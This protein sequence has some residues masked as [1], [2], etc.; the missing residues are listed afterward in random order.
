MP[1]CAVFYIPD[2]RSWTSCDF[3]EAWNIQAYVDV[4]D[5]IR[6]CPTADW[7]CLVRN[8]NTTNSP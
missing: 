7:D 8:M 3:D 4:E 6:G 5:T 2:T 1:V